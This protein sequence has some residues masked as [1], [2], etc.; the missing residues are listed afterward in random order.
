MKGNGSIIVKSA[1]LTL[2]GFLVMVIGY[3]VAEYFV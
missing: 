2:L 3:G 1:V